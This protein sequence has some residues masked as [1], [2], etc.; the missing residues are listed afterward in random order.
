[1][2]EAICSSLVLGWHFMSPEELLFSSR[3]GYI[4]AYVCVDDHRWALEPAMK[5]LEPR[6][7][8]G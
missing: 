2:L 3:V 6:K 7:K 8:H 4:V 5:R 1:M